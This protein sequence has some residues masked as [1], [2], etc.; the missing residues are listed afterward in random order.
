MPHTLC[1]RS[2]YRFARK[3]PNERTGQSAMTPYCP[4]S[5]WWRHRSKTML[6][7]QRNNGHGMLTLACNSAP[8][9]HNCS[10]ECAVCGNA[11]RQTSQSTNM[12]RPQTPTDKQT[13][14]QTRPGR[15]RDVPEFALKRL[16]KWIRQTPLRR[17]FCPTLLHRF[18]MQCTQRCACTCCGNVIR[19]YARYIPPPPPLPPAAAHYGSPADCTL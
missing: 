17:Q 16:P 4:P 18:L 9:A 2:L 15:L 13:N 1:R 8:T 10:T 6:R 3:L 12:N 11:D 14:R 5:P 7:I 19:K